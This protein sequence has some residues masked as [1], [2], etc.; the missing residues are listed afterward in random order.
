MDLII[1]KKLNVSQ[2]E[3]LI[4]KHL[5]NKLPKKKKKF[6]PIIKDVRIFYNTI[7]SA[8]KT[9]RKAGVMVKVQKKEEKE[10]VKYIV[11]I[12]NK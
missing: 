5:Q 3:K 12:P 2:T 11:K 8:V 6:I 4:E 9:M 1:E 10:C 7:N